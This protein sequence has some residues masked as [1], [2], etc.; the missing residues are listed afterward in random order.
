MEVK[1]QIKKIKSIDSL[2][3]SFPTES[4]LYA[5]TGENGS[6]KSTLISSA[7]TLFFNMPMKDYFGK[8]EDACISFSLGETTRKWECIN[9]VWKR[10]S[11]IDRMQIN[12]FYEGSIAFGNRFKD[13]NFSTIKKLEAV[14]KKDLYKADEFIITNL[15]LILHDDSSYY[16][17]L[18]VLSKGAAENLKLLGVHHFYLTNTGEYISQ[19]RMSTGEN[20]LIS[21]LY[22]LKIIYNKRIMHKD[23]KPCI[24]FLDEVELAL[25]SS[26]LRR[27]ILFLKRIS[28]ELNMAVFFSTHSLELIREIKPQNIYYLQQNVDHTISITN[29]CYPAFATRN[30][31]GDDGYGNDVVILVED[32][33]AKLIVDKILYE[34]DLLKNIR[35][36]VLPTGGWT[37]TIT[38]AYDITSSHL[39]NKGTKLFVVLDKD[40]KDEVP[41]FIKNHKEYS[42]ISIDY[43]PIKSLE[44]Y[45]KDNLFVRVD[46]SLYN[47]YDTYLFQKRPI[48]TIINEYK[49]E[50]KKDDFDGKILMGF[51]INELKSMRKDREDL[52]DITVKYLMKNQKENIQQ[53]TR[54]LSEKMSN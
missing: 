46:N 11:S 2:S 34:N 39:L 51:I 5:I 42:G 16:K 40:I 52:V 32:D 12:G 43:L 17:N 18:F 1:M 21:I 3:F 38:L 37:N 27:L 35:L 41:G 19:I 49:R 8:P 23:F 28:D 13:N 31:Y 6:G 45:L 47:Y 24:I 54:Y 30:L 26:A 53:L 36:K 29:P 22:S 48:S 10:T 50:N 33:F 44:K 9:G 15:G 14:S 7:A 20:L 4:G 25:H